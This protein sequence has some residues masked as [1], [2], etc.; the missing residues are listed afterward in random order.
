[1]N[2]LTAVI[3]DDENNAGQALE[4]LLDLYCPEVTVCA[5]CLNLS[6]AVIKINSLRP[7]L[8][9]LDINVGEQNGFDLLDAVAY[10]DFQ[11][12]FSTAHTEYAVRAFRVNA[13]D[14]L[15]KPICP[16]EL[17]ASV[18]KI[19]L[20]KE[21]KSLSSLVVPEQ[22]IEPDTPKTITQLTVSTLE[23]VYVIAVADILHIAGSGNYSTFHL[24]GGS[25]ITASKSLKHFAGKLP[26]DSFFRSHQS[27]LV[28]LKYIKKILSQD[29]VI[30]LKNDSYV[31]LAQSRKS[32]LLNSINLFTR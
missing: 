16:D 28:N 12:I 22:V 31:P 17:K 19:K 8:V 14:Y 4:S 10:Q 32:G 25:K 26:D 27:Y 3:V 7:D 13:T 15:L 20:I 21:N 2:F 23:G 1:M 18:R 24:N 5:R 29:S 30:Q 11:T 6:D 9:F